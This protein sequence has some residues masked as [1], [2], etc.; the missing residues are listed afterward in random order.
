[1][2]AYWRLPGSGRR[3]GTEGRGTAA[4]VSRDVYRG[5][6]IRVEE[7]EVTTP[8]G[9]RWFEVVEHPGAVVLVPLS[10]D[11]VWLVRQPRPAARGETLLEL[12]AGTLRA[13]ETPEAAAVRECREEIGMEP[14]RLTKL[15]EFYAAPGYS[16]ELLH[17]YLAEELRPAPLPPDEDEQLSLERWPLAEALAE[18]RRGRF[19]DAKTL[20]GLLL[21][22]AVRLSGGDGA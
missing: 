17:C 9:L 12:P 8:G 2:G 1:M 22:G 14:G 3:I 7:R 20:V 18:A 21:A 19:R 10:G 6:L 11:S 13:G 5:R 15:V 16:S 4:L